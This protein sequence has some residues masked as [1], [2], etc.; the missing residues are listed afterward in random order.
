MN[1]DDSPG[2]GLKVPGQTGA[3]PANIE[4]T[5]R[6]LV[7]ASLMHGYTKSGAVHLGVQVNLRPKDGRNLRTAR[8]RRG[9]PGGAFRPTDRP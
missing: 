8:R 7:S 6:R 2:L 5:M 1:S 3:M 9:E 4:E